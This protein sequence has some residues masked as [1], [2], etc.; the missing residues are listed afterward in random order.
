M[1]QSS[2]NSRGAAILVFR[3]RRATESPIQRAARISASLGRTKQPGK[4]AAERTPYKQHSAE[5][6]IGEPVHA[7]PHTQDASLTT[8]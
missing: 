4:S 5:E 8:T 7:T 3:L 6:E 2:Q 1:P